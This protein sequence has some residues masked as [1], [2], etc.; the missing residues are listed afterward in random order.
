MKLRHFSFLLFVLLFVFASCSKFQKIQKSTSIVEKYD[1]AV[2][3]YKAG[4]YYRAGLL[5][6]ELI[7]LMRGKKEAEDTEFYYAYC[8]YYQR[9]LYLS[10]YYFKK[11]YQTYPRSEF[12]QEAHYMHCR[13]LYE[14]SPRDDLDQSTTKDAMQAIQSFLK[15]YPKSEFADE[16]QRI[17]GGLDKKLNKKYFESAKLY[18]K[19]RKYKSAV[20]SLENYR[21]KYP[22]SQYNEEAQYL[23]ID[24]QYNYAKKSIESKK[25]ERFYETISLYQEFVDKYPASQYLGEAEKIYENCLKEIE[26]YNQS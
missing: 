11:F 24:A 16:V 5:F 26:D 9:Q 18:H 12:A 8:Q 21:K 20:V 3:Y 22:D 17:Y 1:A 13:S 2:K 14:S 10:A 7:P 15:K 4:D 25:K 23:R 6:E 19:I